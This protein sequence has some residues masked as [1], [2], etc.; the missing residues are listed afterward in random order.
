MRS[1]LKDRPAQS[2]VGALDKVGSFSLG[3]GGEGLTE[4]ADAL[5][6]LL[7][8]HERQQKLFKYL[9]LFNPC[10]YPEEGILWLHFTNWKTLQG[11]L[12]LSGKGRAWSRGQ[13][14]LAPA[15][16]LSAQPFPW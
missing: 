6:N 5:V 8:E 13:V 15:P 14:G 12:P 11:S 4:D 9:I 1:V 7:E 2:T 10:H 3:R 16:E